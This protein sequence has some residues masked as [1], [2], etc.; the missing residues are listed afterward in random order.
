MTE[1]DKVYE[2]VKK[3]SDA[4]YRQV[5]ETTDNI[6]SDLDITHVTRRYKVESSLMALA[7][8]ILRLR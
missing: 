2:A 6:C 5:V 4:V 7:A 1:S 8:D 3:H